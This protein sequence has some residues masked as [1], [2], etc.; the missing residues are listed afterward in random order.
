MIMIA[1]HND[2]LCHEHD[3]YNDVS[4]RDN[5]CHNEVSRSDYVTMF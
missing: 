1:T 4:C 3:C 2:V 5:D